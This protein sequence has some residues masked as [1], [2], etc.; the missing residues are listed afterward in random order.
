MK[1]NRPKTAIP[2]SVYREMGLGKRRGNMI[3][4]VAGVTLNWWEPDF[5]RRPEVVYASILRIKNRE[6]R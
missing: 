6:R 2:A 1:R 5:L 4:V 3:K